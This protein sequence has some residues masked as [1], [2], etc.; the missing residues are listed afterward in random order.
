MW[1]DVDCVNWKKDFVCEHENLLDADGNLK[2]PK[3]A[4]NPISS[5]GVYEQIDTSAFNSKLFHSSKDDFY[6]LVIKLRKDYFHEKLKADEK[7]EL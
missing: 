7:D 3:F 6:W 1:Y 4:K 5:P 2:K